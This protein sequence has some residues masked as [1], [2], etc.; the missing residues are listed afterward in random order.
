VVD[1]D[2]LYAGVHYGDGLHAAQITDDL[3]AR[4]A[5]PDP[6]IDLT[7]AELAAVQDDRRSRLGAQL[8]PAILT[9]LARLDED[10]PPVDVAPYLAALPAADRARLVTARARLAAWTFD[11]P[12][13]ASDDSAA[14]A[15]FHTWLRRFT[16]RALGDELDGIGIPLARLDDDQRARVIHA[17]LTDPRSF[18]TSPATQQ[19]ILCDNYPAAG[20]DDSCTK[21]ILEAM[22]D[23]MTFLESP[24]GFG[25]ADT[26]AWA[27]GQLH[28]LALTSV[29]PG[30]AAPAGMPLAGDELAADRAPGSLAADGPALRWL[31][32]AGAGE[33]TVKWALPG[34]VIFDGRSSHA[35]DQLD[36]A[37]RSGAYLEAPI[38]F[39]QIVA[40]GETRWVFH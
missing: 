30:V 4:A 21:V 17:M 28:A 35:R 9:A 20:P 34:G 38:T 33:I 3:R 15:I 36:G 12:A 5:D 10:G 13:S 19:P 8:V 22:V 29:V 7:V 23:A 37:Y 24:A 32:E 6:R 25:T 39:A 27:W 26:S 31:A 11:T 14:T 1:G 2:P 16:E 18:I 40:A